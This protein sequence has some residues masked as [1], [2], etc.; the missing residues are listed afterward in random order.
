MKSYFFILVLLICLSC[1]K[2]DKYPEIQIYGHAGSGID[3]SS[4]PYQENTYEAVEYALGY[5]EISGVE[6]DV[7]W[8]K[9][10]TPWLYHDDDLSVQ[11]NGSGNIS[12]RTDEELSGVRYKGLNGEDLTKLVD[13]AGLVGAKELI[14]DMKFSQVQL[15]QQEIEEGLSEFV[16]LAAESKVSVILQSMDLAPYFQSMGWNVYLNAN[17][18]DDYF[19]TP[20][21][22][23]SNGCCISNTNIEQ[24]GVTLIREAGKKVIIFS[25]RAPKTIRKAL[26][27]NPDIFL[28]DD[29]R[30]TLI[31]KIR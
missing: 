31:E 26:K 13:I 16:N 5:S 7:Q 4:S 25:A 3:I 1:K 8:S 23:N 18:T 17:S 6:V 21:W 30:A 9:D 15:T 22:E 11:T 10:G 14:L 28:A 20:Q 12:E 29:I 27:K 24:S 19:S 2:E